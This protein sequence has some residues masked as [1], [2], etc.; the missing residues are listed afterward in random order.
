M[1]VKQD[2]TQDETDIDDY[3]DI[4][5]PMREMNIQENRQATD[6]TNQKGGE[7]YSMQDENVFKAYN[8]GSS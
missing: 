3:S 5:K 2:A 4:N 1:L 7:Y 8:S 6:S